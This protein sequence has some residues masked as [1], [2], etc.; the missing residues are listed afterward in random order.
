MKKA[1]SLEKETPEKWFF[2]AMANWQ[3]GDKTQARKDYDQAIGS[4]KPSD[5]KDV[6]L[7]RFKGEAAA[8]LQGGD[9]T[10]R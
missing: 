5:A 6:E 2:L 10:E 4:M 9:G 7:L 3:L 8:L 1:L